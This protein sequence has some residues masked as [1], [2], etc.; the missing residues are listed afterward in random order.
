MAVN[1][2]ALSRGIGFN[3]APAREPEGQPMILAGFQNL[4]PT[5][6]ALANAGGGYIADVY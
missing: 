1:M 4:K 5:Q 2:R 6:I 3:N